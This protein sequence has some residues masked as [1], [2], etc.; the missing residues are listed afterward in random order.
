MVI[1]TEPVWEEFIEK[2]V[3]GYQSAVVYA[4]FGQETVL[5]EGELRILPDGWSGFP[6]GRLLSPE[7][8][9]HTDT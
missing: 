2:F 8:I 4:D 7:A 9:H 1:S 5:H 6:T 3:Q